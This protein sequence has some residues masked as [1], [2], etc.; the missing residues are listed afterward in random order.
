MSATRVTAPAGW[1]GGAV[2]DRAP[3]AAMS[4]VGRPP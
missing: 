1:L 3:E 2:I 4:T